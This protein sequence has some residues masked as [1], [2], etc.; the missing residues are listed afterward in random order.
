MRGS[1]VGL[2]S[3]CTWIGTAPACGLCSGAFING[4]AAISANNA[5][6]APR[7]GKTW[8]RFET[9]LR[10]KT[11]KVAADISSSG[12]CRI[13]HPDP[14]QG[15]AS[16]APDSWRCSRCKRICRRRLRWPRLP[17]T[18]PE[19]SWMRIWQVTRTAQDHNGSTIC[20]VRYLVTAKVKTGQEK[21]LD[22]AIDRRTLG[23]GS[24]AGDEYLRN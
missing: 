14:T 23:R 13:Q 15:I 10:R 19:K 20:R 24:I 3:A 16:A 6:P 9:V 21:S 17:R 1:G 4:A 8:R 22:S 11:S 18:L 5:R 7:K 12:D 2:C